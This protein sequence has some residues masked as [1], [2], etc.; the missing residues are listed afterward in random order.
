MEFPKE[1]LDELHRAT[2]I[3]GILGKFVTWDS[4]KTKAAKGDYWACCPFHSEKTPSFHATEST[5]TYYCFSCQAKGTALTFLQKNRGLSFI[6][7]VKFLAEEAGLA[8]PKLT[9]KEKQQADKY[10]KLYQLNQLAAQYFQ[11]RLFSSEGKKA[12]DYIINRGLAIETVKEFGLGFAPSHNQL[13][14]HL[15]SISSSDEYIVDSG[16]AKKRDVGEGIYPTFRNRI[17]FPIKNLS[18]REIAFGGR[19]MD[20]NNPAKYLNSPN[21]EIFNKGSILYN[22]Q[23]ATKNMDRATP[24]MIVAEG[25]LDVIALSE[26][27]YKSTVAPMGTALT[28]QQLKTLWRY[29]PKPIFAMDGDNAGLLAASRI[30]ELALS[31]LFK[32]NGAKFCLMPEGIDPDDFIRKFGPQSFQERLD[33]AHELWEFLWHLET[34]GMKAISSHQQDTINA[35]LQ[36]KLR[37]IKDSSIRGIYKSRIRTLFFE[38]FLRKESGKQKILKDVD[39]SEFK[40]FLKGAQ[41][42]RELSKVYQLEALILGIL[43]KNPQLI[44]A[45]SELLEEFEFSSEKET[46]N[47][48]KLELLLGDFKT[49]DTE[50]IKS[51]SAHSQAITDIL[52][53]NQLDICKEFA[54]T[55]DDSQKSKLLKKAFAVLESEKFCDE[56]SSEIINSSS[57]LDTKEKLFLKLRDEKRR[58]PFNSDESDA[59]AFSAEDNPIQAE[60]KVKQYINE[61]QS[62]ALDL[63][64]RNTK[65]AQFQGVIDENSD[66]DLE[67]LK[68]LTQ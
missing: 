43:I 45:F 40:D 32:A 50:T 58:F 46:F 22:L 64:S 51:Q 7:S 49:D 5:K 30:A 26:A 9:G 11:D 8:L 67:E 15:R 60:E 59:E 57:N 63:P 34:Q 42:L 6:D 23:D 62:E 61:L 56:V 10:S 48:I 52:E 4:K 44:P 53:L 21:T 12:L 19:A 39:T 24:S 38:T 20:P 29:V 14:E 2:S 1:F 25:Y 3:S 28:E 66:D 16:L 54:S 41:N 31:L 36:D 13:F 33:H 17:V 47:S 37:T 68:K 18:G 35:N 55:S 65:E 27:G